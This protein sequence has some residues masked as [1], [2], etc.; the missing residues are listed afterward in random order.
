M[1]CLEPARDY[2]GEL[3]QIETDLRRSRS[4]IELAGVDQLD[5]KQLFLFGLREPFYSS[6]RKLLRVSVYVLRFI[7]L[8]VWR[9]IDGE[10]FK[11]K[12]MA[13]VLD[14]LSEGFIS[15][16]EI[17]MA[18][19]LWIYSVQQ[20]YFNDVFIAL[21]NNKKHCL[22]KQLGLKTDQFGILRCYGRY[23]NADVSEEMKHPKLLPRK[24]FF[25][26]LVILEIH[27]HLIHAG[28]LHTL[29]QLREEFWI[30]QGRA[31]VRHVLYQCV[32]C[33]RHDG[34]SF[35]LPNMPPWPKERVAT[36]ESF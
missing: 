9:K 33:K 18:S 4:F 35:C 13:V 15:R 21:K 5:D 36:R 12:L 19:I 2:C 8:K 29:S 6:L 34:K 17:K 14:S 23:S 11:H 22:Q 30:P 3:E 32:V 24:C 31:E 26:Q 28:V 20:S 16:T 27:V 25:T 1:A 7:K 10:R